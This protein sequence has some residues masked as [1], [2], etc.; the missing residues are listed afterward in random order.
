MSNTQPT[1]TTE[2]KRWYYMRV[3]KSKERLEA[4]KL[5]R[6]GL[7]VGNIA[8]RLGVSKSSVSTWCEDIQLTS[9]QRTQLLKNKI[10]G[11]HRGRIIG[12]ETNRNKRL[13]N[14][15]EQE[16]VARSMIGDLTARDK[17]MIGIALY[18]GEGT[19][20]VHSS[21]T[22]ITNSDPEAVLFARNWFEQ[23]G[24]ERSMFQPYIF[25]SETHRMREKVIMRFWSRYLHISARQFAPIIFLK[26]RPKKIYENH[27]SYYGVVA[28]RVRKGK[29]LKYLILG[30]IKACKEKAGV[31][32]LVRAVVS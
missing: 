31:A 14:M 18:W 27:N 29:S 10:E 6:R 22:A 21:A 24:V 9:E 1:S 8:Q 25:I 20:A 19:K 30:L 28:L 15:A 32:Q 16:L 7:S 11:G 23:L 3:A 4:L 2:P 13:K 26:G 17:L 5:R 12:A